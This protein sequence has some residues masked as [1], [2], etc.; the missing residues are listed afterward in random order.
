[1]PRPSLEQLVSAYKLEPEV[2]AA[3]RRPASREESSRR[4]ASLKTGS[5]SRRS[6]PPMTR[7]DGTLDLEKALRTPCPERGIKQW[8]LQAR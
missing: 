5:S 7:D 6:M 3:M 2:V 1:M 4:V 8:K